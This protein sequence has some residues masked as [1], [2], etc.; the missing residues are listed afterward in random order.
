MILYVTNIL[1]ILKQ[2][3]QEELGMIMPFQVVS[4]EFVLKLETLL[5]FVLAKSWHWFWDA[6]SLSPLF[7]I[8]RDGVTPQGDLRHSGAVLIH[9]G[10]TCDHRDL[11]IH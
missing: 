4:L 9:L 2:S 11:N 3:S 8:F 5:Y 7:Y 1:C 6:G 10:A